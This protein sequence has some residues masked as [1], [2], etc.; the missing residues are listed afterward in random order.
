MGRTVTVT[1]RGRASA[2]YDEATL[3]LAATARAA[4]PSDATARAPYSLAAL[5]VAGLAASPPGRLL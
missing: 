4:N 2:A 1:G 5:P 3:R